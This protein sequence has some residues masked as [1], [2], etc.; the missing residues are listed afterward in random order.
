MFQDTHDDKMLF[1]ERRDDLICLCS[2]GTLQSIKPIRRLSDTHPITPF[3]PEDAG[4]RD[5]AAGEEF[6]EGY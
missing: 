5:M 2:L 3:F 1:Y 6:N 4:S